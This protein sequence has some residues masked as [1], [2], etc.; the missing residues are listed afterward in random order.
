M[1]VTVVDASTLQPLIKNSSEVD[2]LV[3]ALIR[4][5]GT[6][7]QTMDKAGS[8]TDEI[9]ETARNN[10]NT[11]SQQSMVL[12]NKVDLL[13]ERER[14]ILKEVMNYLKKDQGFYICGFSCKTLEGLD[15]FLEMLKGTVS[16]L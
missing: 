13:A 10:T 4:K 12:F 6:L 9:A 16:K 8:I 14:K 2:D 3:T 15:T 11:T 7:Q 1:V 5:L